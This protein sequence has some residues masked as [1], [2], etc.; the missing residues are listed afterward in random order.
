M[1]NETPRR[2]I[3]VDD[4]LWLAAQTKAAQEGTTVSEHIR[5][6]LKANNT[7][8]VVILSMENIAHAARTTRHSI[9]DVLEIIEA[10]KEAK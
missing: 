4:A 3:R 9:A 2:A 10:L 1:T 8:D 6:L 7:G 5:E